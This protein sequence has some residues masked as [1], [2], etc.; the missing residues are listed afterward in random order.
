MTHRTHLLCRYHSLRAVDLAQNSHI[1]FFFQYIFPI[2]QYT[3]TKLRSRAKHSSL[4]PATVQSC[5]K[6][7][8][9]RLYE[10]LTSWLHVNTALQL[11]QWIFPDHQVSIHRHERIKIKSMMLQ[12]GDFFYS[13]NIS[14]K[15]CPFTV[16]SPL[17]NLSN[18][19]WCI[20]HTVS[21]GRRAVK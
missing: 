9:V 11:I 5:R 3:L 19:A 21:C 14:Q 13:T 4:M 12:N 8:V 20:Y 17:L 16:I 1:L 10:N 6:N 7:R 2:S 18:V 15:A